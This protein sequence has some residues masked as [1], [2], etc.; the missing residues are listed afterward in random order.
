[1]TAHPHTDACQPPPAA[2]AAVSALIAEHAAQDPLTV[3]A[4][5]RLKNLEEQ[6]QLLHRE[7]DEARARVVDL[8]AEVANLRELAESHQAMAAWKDDILAQQDIENARLAR[9][10]ARLRDHLARAGLA[11]DELTKPKGIAP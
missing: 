9:V 8:E 1:M 3:W 11:L 10:N 6:R 2:V 4:W 5:A 7:R